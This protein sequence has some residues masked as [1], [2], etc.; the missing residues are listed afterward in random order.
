MSFHVGFETVGN[1]TLIVHDGAPLLVTDPWITGSA[2]FGSWGLAHEIP[3]EQSDAVRH[4]QYVWISHGHPDHLSGD[5]LALLRDK[6]ILFPT[7]EAR[8]YSTICARRGSTSACCRIANG[9]SSRRACACSASPTT[10]RTPSCS[11]T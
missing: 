9:S 7:T 1:A 8:G 4:C 6:A 11:S 2:Y 3:A 10:T 5:S